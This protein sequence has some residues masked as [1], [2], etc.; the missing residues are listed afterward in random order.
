MIKWWDRGGE[1]AS[2]STVD[3]EEVGETARDGDGASD[4]RVRQLRLA[5]ALSIAASRR[6][7]GRIFPR[8]IAARRRLDAAAC[9]RG[10]TTCS[11]PRDVALSGP[12][13]LRSADAMRERYPAVENCTTERREEEPSASFGAAIGIGSFPRW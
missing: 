5:M 7:A 11:T 9:L 4:A 10:C 1:G 12:L 3:A 6:A 13:R 2:V 8:F